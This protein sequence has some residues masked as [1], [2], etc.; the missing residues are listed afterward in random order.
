MR[1]NNNVLLNIIF[2][3]NYSHIIYFYFLNVNQCFDFS[4]TAQLDPQVH[5]SHYF[6]FRRKNPGKIPFERRA[7]ESVDDKINSLY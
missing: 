7:Y 1:V 4:F 3:L 2:V 6:D 5:F